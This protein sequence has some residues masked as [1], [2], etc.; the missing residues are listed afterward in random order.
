MQQKIKKTTINWNVIVV[1]RFCIIYK[2][3]VMFCTKNDLL[4]RPK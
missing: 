3:T 1:L 2:R 4:A